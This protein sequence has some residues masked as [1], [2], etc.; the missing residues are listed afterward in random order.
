MMY[1]YILVYTWSSFVST[2][3]RQ[4]A[5]LWTQIALEEELGTCKPT[6][7]QRDIMMILFNAV[8]IRWNNNYSV[9]LTEI[10][11]IRVYTCIYLYIPQQQ[12][13]ILIPL[14]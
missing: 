13:Y 10:K 4:S 2:V 8:R 11:Y 12:T 6:F 3:P 5:I 1:K 14:D 9:L 7:F